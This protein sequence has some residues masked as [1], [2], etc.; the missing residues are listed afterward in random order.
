MEKEKYWYDPTPFELAIEG[1][2]RMEKEE[3]KKEIESIQSGGGG[4]Y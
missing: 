1:K 3:N 2:Q 4:G